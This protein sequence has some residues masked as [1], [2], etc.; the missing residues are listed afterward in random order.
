ML[1]LA[2]IYFGDIRKDVT[3]TSSRYWMMH[4]SMLTSAYMIAFKLG[5][6]GP[7]IGR[8]RE[9]KELERERT[10]LL[11]SLGLDPLGASLPLHA[12]QLAGQ[13]AAGAPGPQ[14]ASL[15][16][17][18]QPPLAAANHAVHNDP[19]FVGGGHAVPLAAAAALPNMQHVHPANLPHHPPPAAANVPHHAPVHQHP[20][21]PA[22]HAPAH[23]QPQAA[24][25]HAPAHPQPQAAAK[26]PPPNQQNGQAQPPQ[27]GVVRGICD[28]CRA[29][30]M[31]AD[32]GRV[33]EGDKYYHAACIKGS[34]GGCHLIVHADAERK[35]EGGVYW[36]NDCWLAATNHH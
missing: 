5:H 32:D 15:V 6:V 36:H 1:V 3:L 25:K 24:A 4:V 22:K 12:A 29:N 21:A 10:Q 17:A 11:A 20:P 31:D 9:K 2:S 19:E 18:Q 8:L 16:G 14:P 34:C 28:G 27:N 26:H 23:P 33:R 35:K 30:V 13:G 7:F